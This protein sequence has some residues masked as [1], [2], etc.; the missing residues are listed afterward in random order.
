[1]IKQLMKRIG[2]PSP[3]SLSGS[4]R[5]MDSLETLF[6]S[7]L[8]SYAAALDSVSEAASDSP[9]GARE[10]FRRKLKQIRGT[11][12]VAQDDDTFAE[13]RRQFDAEV[14]RFGRI[15]EDHAQTQE[16]DAKEIMAIVATMADSIASREK[17][18]NVRFKGIA[19]KLRLLTTSSDLAEIKQRLSEE[20]GQ[21]D[22]Y[23]DD[24][25]RDTQAALDRVRTGLQARQE[26][27]RIQPWIEEAVDP[28]TKLAG[29]PEA[30]AALAARMRQDLGF[31]IVLFAVEGYAELSTRQSRAYMDGLMAEF[32]QRMRSLLPDVPALCR[33]NEAEVM[34]LLEGNLPDAAGRALEMERRLS[35]AYSIRTEAGEERVAVSCVSS[36]LQPLR[37]ESGPQLLERLRNGR[38]REPALLER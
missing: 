13:C 20:V 30:L 19:R 7:A 35:G 16:R 34:A 37:G 32:A 17:Q 6:A 8:E 33:W 15:V 22:K 3:G 31:C 12:R 11:I 4:M 2:G 1:M 10:E 9:R 25:A 21:L 36:V 18:H 5:K 24:M 26:G 14:R 38:R 29:R 23:V 28:V 27:R